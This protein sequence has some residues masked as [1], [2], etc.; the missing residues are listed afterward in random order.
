MET[1]LYM[2]ENT[3][4]QKSVTQEIQTQ[5]QATGRERELTKRTSD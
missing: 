2:I 5:D 4:K 1:K 3:E